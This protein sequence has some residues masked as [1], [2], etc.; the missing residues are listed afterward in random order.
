MYLAVVRSGVSLSFDE[1]RNYRRD[2]SLIEKTTTRMAMDN[3]A[4]MANRLSELSKVLDLIY[5]P[6][7]GPGRDC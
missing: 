2:M 4:E 7:T 3:R 6:E 5:S 1:A